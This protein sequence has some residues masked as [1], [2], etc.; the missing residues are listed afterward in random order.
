MVGSQG[1]VDHDLSGTGGSDTLISSGV[2]MASSSA[3]CLMDVLAP[4]PA[5]LGAAVAGTRSLVVREASGVVV[6][7][8]ERSTNSGTGVFV[9]GKPSGDVVG[10]R[11]TNSGS[12][13][14]VVGD[15]SGTRRS[16]GEKAIGV[17][18]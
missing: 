6:V 15:R 2:E 14:F 8:G 3:S 12:G 9:G 10:E 7:V 11:S 17:G 4:C 5:A 18:R 16:S 13:A 1:V